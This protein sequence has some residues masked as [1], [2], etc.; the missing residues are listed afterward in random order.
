MRLLKTILL[1]AIALIFIVSCEKNKDAISLTNIYLPLE[2]GNYWQ[3]DYLTKKEV[4]GTKKIGDKIYHLIQY[5]NDT[6]YYRIE[7]DK[8]YVIEY[9]DNESVKF[10]LSAKV[11]DTW[12]YHSYMVK[13]VSKTDTIIVNDT[14]FIN[15]FQFFYDVPGLVDEE[16]SIWLAP[17]VGF[18]QEQCGEC[19]H[20]I[21]K[22]DKAK[23][24]GQEMDY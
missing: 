11:N 16:H 9:E 13:L 20:Q 7:N 15:C 24:N 4:V 14:K 12:N 10:N 23:I 2:I 5:Q 22:L 18:V 1:F 17:N 21:K 8:V 3:L 6:T 19:L